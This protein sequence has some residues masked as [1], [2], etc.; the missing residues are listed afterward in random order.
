MTELYRK[1]GDFVAAGL[2]LLLSIALSVFLAYTAYCAET[3]MVQIYQDGN[4]LYEQPLEQDGSYTVEGDYRNTVTIQ[5]GMVSVSG[6]NCP[7]EDCVHSG[8]ISQAGRAIVCLPNKLE[9]RL[10]GEAEIDALAR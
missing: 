8:K 1:K 10:T 3:I 9:I 5:N 6:S 7:G 2:V 4:L